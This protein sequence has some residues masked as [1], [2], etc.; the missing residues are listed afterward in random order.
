MGAGGAAATPL[1]LDLVGD[2]A[3]ILFFFFPEDFTGAGFLLFLP[4]LVVGPWNSGEAPRSASGL[5]GSSPSWA[6]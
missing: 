2:L 6:P 3:V 4:D 5:S 1:L